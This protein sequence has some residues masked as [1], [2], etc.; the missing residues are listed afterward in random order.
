MYKMYCIMSN[1]AI[2]K[3]NGI[4]G[5]ATSQAGHAFLHAFWDAEQRFPDSAHAYKFSNQAKKI[6]LVVPNEESL[7]E[8]RDYYSRV[9]GTSL[10]KD[11]GI[12]VFNEPTVTCLG[13]GPIH[14]NDIDKNLSTLP[15]LT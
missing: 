14:V 8:L 10:V 7:V 3:M 1:E 5:K 11:A 12:T 2:K 13:I 15:L 4:R 6:T 9:T